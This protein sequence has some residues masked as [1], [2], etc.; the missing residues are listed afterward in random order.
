MGRRPKEIDRKQFENLCGLQCTHE[1]KKQRRLL[2]INVRGK[3]AKVTRRPCVYRYID[4]DDGIVKYV[5]IVYKNS[6][7]KRIQDHYYTDDWCFGKRWTIE[8]FEC[9][10]RSE[11][12]AFESHLISLYGS[13]KYYNKAK[14]NW[15]INRF[16]PDVEKLWKVAETSDFSDQETLE[17]ALLFRLFLRNKEI[18]KARKIYEFFEFSELRG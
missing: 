4:A 12:E 17:A 14:S 18:E 10:T 8:Y 9:D 6:L 7:D 15:G 13:D 5:G 2:G 16:L 3:T 1:A 11:A